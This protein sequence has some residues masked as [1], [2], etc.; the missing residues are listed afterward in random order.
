MRAFQINLWCSDVAAL[1][2]AEWAAGDFTQCRAAA[3][4]NLDYL[5]RYI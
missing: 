3:H 4:R 2:I 1:N 5:K